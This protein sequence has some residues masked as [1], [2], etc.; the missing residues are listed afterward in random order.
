MARDHGDRSDRS[1]R[2]WTKVRNEGTL[3]LRRTVEKTRVG[4]GRE[5]MRKKIPTPVLVDHVTRGRKCRKA[6]WVASGKKIPT[7][8]LVDH[9][10][11]S[12]MVE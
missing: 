8:V 12:E 3:L 2:G 7:P 9:A 4:A 11:W 10:A 6:P 5:T 1:A